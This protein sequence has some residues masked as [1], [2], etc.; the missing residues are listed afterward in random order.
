MRS[1]SSPAAHGVP[2]R[3][4]LAGTT[5]RARDVFEAPLALETLVAFF[6]EA[7]FLGLWI[8]SW[9]RLNRYAHLALIWAVTLTA[10]AS[11]YFVLVANGFMKNPV[12][13]LRAGDDPRIDSAAT[14]FTNL[15]ALLPLAHIGAGRSWSPGSSWAASAAGTCGV[16]VSRSSSRGRCGS[17]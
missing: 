1:G 7:T 9:D 2:V 17:A 11:A 3:A 14:L 4:E 16:P 12:G 5:D 6:V 8:F 15:A 13:Y 10:F